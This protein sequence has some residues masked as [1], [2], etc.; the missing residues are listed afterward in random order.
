VSQT[1]AIH[2]RVTD[3]QSGVL[4]GV[5]VTATSPSQMAAQETTTNAAGFYFFPALA[6]GTY[7]LRYE[8]DQFAS[9][10]RAGIDVP[11]GVT[12]TVDVS[13]SLAPIQ[14]DVTAVVSR[15]DT[16]TARVQTNFAQAPLAA[17][18]NARDLWALLSVTTGLQM[19]RWD[20]GGN[21]SGNQ[22]SY[23]AYGYGG[24][25]QQARILVEG[26]NTTDGRSANGFFQ[27]YGSFD[28]VIV[29]AA[30]NG[31]EVPHPGVTAQMLTKSGS[32]LFHAGLYGDYGNDD[33]QQRID[34]SLEAGGPVRSDRLWYY[35]A[36]RQLESRIDQVNL[37]IG[38]PFET[39][40]F[41]ASGK[42]TYRL[43]ES[44]TF[45]GYYQWGNK[46]QPYRAWNAGYTFFDMADTTRQDDGSSVW[47]GEWNRVS[48]HALIEARYGGFGYYLPLIGNSDEP[49]R[50]DTGTRV[51]SGGDRRTQSDRDRKQL[52]VVATTFHEG[53]AGVRHA[54]R[55][56]VEMNL[57]AAWT[58]FERTRAGHV[59][60]I[61][62]NGRATQVILGFPT[63]DGP[64]GGR[65]AR[66]RLLSMARL[67]QWSGF[68]SDEWRVRDALTLNLGVRFDHYRSHVPEQRQL[69]FTNGP[70]TIVAETFPAH[71]FY[72]WRSLVP[73]VAAIYQLGADG[74]TVAKASYGYF[75]HNP[76]VD[77]ATA[78]NPN[79]GTKTITY[80]WTDRNG[81]RLY[82]AGEEGGV[83]ASNLANAVEVDPD[84]RQPYTHELIASV[85]R[86]VGGAASVRAGVVHK[87]NDD[88]WQP[89]RPLRPID[90]YTT[91]F[92]IRDI[93]ADG[94]AGTADDRDLVFY[95]TPNA[96]LGPATTV[97]QTVPAF[98]RYTAIETSFERRPRDGWSVAAGVSYSW[99]HEH[100][101]NY[102]GNNVSP[103]SNP[104][105]PNSPNEMLY[106]NGTEG[107]H[108]FTIW[109][110]KAR[111]TLEA[112]W[113]LRFTPMLRAQAGQPYGRV[114]QVTAPA[115]CACFF[116]GLVLVEPLDA[117][118][119]DTVAVFDLRTEATLPIGRHRAGLFIDVFNAFNSSAADVI[120]YT[121]GPAF[122]QPA[123]V[124]ASR[125]VR[126]GV[127]M[128]W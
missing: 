61:F 120:S 107:A 62:N 69:P 74:N 97:I 7:A 20:I 105:Y 32:N 82:Q 48:D 27:D 101:N 59:E 119:M 100:N 2:G 72:R 15:I 109:D 38:R 44:N 112:P 93:G 96:Q 84:T 114:L 41:N 34:G 76:S 63:A 66:D 106:T 70:V 58:G 79:Q 111:A 89:Y 40:L 9:L 118:R 14:A 8:R 10:T 128:Q 75:R 51:S 35:A 87:T 113:G 116:N 57:E 19:G 104:G 85:E 77:I 81:D 1:G 5:T 73:R 28:E 108:R 92:T 4:A 123:S 42:A 115:S 31:A 65:S 53:A 23:R 68:I 54:L 30:G 88:L 71:T 126:I 60:H 11:L 64:V 55:T 117:R 17:M 110:A 95:G 6:P 52:T 21:R 56:G 125:F 121:T 36:Y 86:Q 99:T 22:T 24:Q 91:P 12:A 103:V 46:Q 37:Q 39:S 29:S 67:D 83:V 18:P 94:G 50:Q 45:V 3:A 25:D 98:G 43:S 16:T 90:G 47:K 13:L 122:A 26:I 124:V 33:T 127:R 49:F 102:I 78:A 80:A